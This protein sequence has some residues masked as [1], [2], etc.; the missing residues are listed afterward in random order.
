MHTVVVGVCKVLVA[1]HFLF[2]TVVF[3][4]LEGVVI[5]VDVSS[6]A[7]SALSFEEV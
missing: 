3:Y 2:L 5:A 1:W 4:A 7:C 6:T